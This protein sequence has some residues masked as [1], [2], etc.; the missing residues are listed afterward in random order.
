MS[1]AL[2]PNVAP[3]LIPAVV[4]VLVLFSFVWA[5]LLVLGKFRTWVDDVVQ[6]RIKSLE[7]RDTERAEAV[8]RSYAQTEAV[9]ARLTARVDDLFRL[10]HD[11]S[12][13]RTP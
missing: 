1:T 9:D 13:K 3:F 12:A 8:R 4:A 11:I 7:A 2:D 10:V 6:D 5:I